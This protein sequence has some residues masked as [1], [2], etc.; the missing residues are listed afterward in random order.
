MKKLCC[1]FNVPVLYREL[2]YK[3]IEK[4]FDCDWYFEEVDGRFKIFDT[5]LLKNVKFLPSKKHRGFITVKGLVTLVWNK[6]YTHYLMLGNTRNLSEFIFLLTKQIFFPSKKVVLWTHGYYGR[7][8]KIVRL[9]KRAFFKLADSIL[10]Y[11]DHAQ[12]LMQADGIN[13]DKMYVV[14]NSLNYDEQLRLRRTISSTSIYPDH[15]G[16]NHPV[17]L[18]IGRLT[19]SKRLDMLIEALAS[20]KQKGK[21]YN[22]VL[23]GDGS[24]RGTLE[25][26]AIEKG[27]SENVWFYGACYDETTNAE[28]VS[29]ADLCVSPGNIGLTAIHALMFGCPCISHDNF[30]YQGPEFEAIK[31]GIT[32]AFYKQGDQNSLTSTISQWFKIYAKDRNVVR[33]AC[34]HEIDTQWNP[35]YQM[36]VIKSVIS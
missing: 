24:I 35:D 23:V 28:L 11:G 20:L 36:E 4:S 30:A 7:E 9:W 25:Q 32:G 16:N 12:N 5:G 10:L 14:H 26:L 27:V 19:T 31:E 1:A 2:I 6:D 8:S 15:F 34:Y 18:F 21:H 22:L 17:L 29:N 13:P 3:R 33:Q